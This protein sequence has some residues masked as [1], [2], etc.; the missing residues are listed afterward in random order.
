MDVITLLTWL[1]IL[2]CISQAGMFSGLNLALFSV[3]RLRLEVEAAAGNIAAQ[4]ILQMRQDANF[5]LCTILW[6][7]VAVNVLLTLLSDS[8]LLGA[9]AFIFS[10]L[11]I[12]VFGEIVPQ[13]YFSRNALR[14]GDFFSPVLKVYG[15]I[16][17]PVA[18]PSAMLLNR[19][20]GR[21]GIHYFHE[22]NMREVI[23]KHMW[24]KESDIGRIE[25]IGA[26]NFLAFDDLQVIQEGELVDDRSIIILPTENGRPVFPDYQPKVSDNFLQQVNVSG[27]KW[28]IITASDGE[29]LLVL[30][31]NRFLRAALLKRMVADPKGYCHRPII[32][33]EPTT[34]LGRV[35]PRLKVDAKSYGDDVIDD[36]LI[37]LWGKEKRIIT[38]SDILGRLLRGI[39]VQKLDIEA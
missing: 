32:V 29:P 23:R 24:S 34:L 37:L 21:E 31:A 30:N 5:L 27:K 28:I 3:S 10:T 16:L 19:W 9:G 26:L 25:G 33:R 8:V 20:L 6:G 22:H 4:K 38:G 2:F 1:G 13:A 36:D 17:Y 12:T 35:I 7:N 11:A 18:K 39:V 15:F 14:L